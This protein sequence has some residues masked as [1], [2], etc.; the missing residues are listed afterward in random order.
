L[1]SSVAVAV[2]GAGGLTEWQ[3][4]ELIALV[5]ESTPD[6]LGLA[7]ISGPAMGSPS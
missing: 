5:R 2:Q 1:P 7:E 4:Q 3:Q 6:Q